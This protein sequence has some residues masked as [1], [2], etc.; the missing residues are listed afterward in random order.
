M[1]TIQTDLQSG[2]IIPGEYES[3]TFRFLYKTL[4][5]LSDALINRYFYLS[6]P[7]TIQEKKD[8]KD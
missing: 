5:F 1:K 3:G 6:L 4:I 8:E 2:L 7:D